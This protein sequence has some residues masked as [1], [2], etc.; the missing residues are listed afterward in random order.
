MVHPNLV[1]SA[2]GSPGLP[3]RGLI[4]FNFR[5]LTGSKYYMCWQRCLG[6]LIQH[7]HSVEVSVT[8]SVLKNTVD[9]LTPAR[10]PCQLELL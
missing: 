5:N 6:V 2:T 3:T 9:S 4:C 1:T 10:L 7:L 8:P